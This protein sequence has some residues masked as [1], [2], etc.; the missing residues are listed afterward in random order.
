MNNDYIVLSKSKIRKNV[1]T[2]F[3]VAVIVSGLVLTGVSDTFIRLELFSLLSAIVVPF[4]VM[5]ATDYLFCLGGKNAKFS[6]AV[7]LT[8]ALLI[9]GK[10]CYNYLCAI[11]GGFVGFTQVSHIVIAVIL[12]HLIYLGLLAFVQMAIIRRLPTKRL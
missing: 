8:E 7:M 12:G 10:L 6:L 9:S 2:V 1:L 5:T 11:D 4:A 3:L